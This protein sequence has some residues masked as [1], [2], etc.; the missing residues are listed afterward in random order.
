MQL[1]YKGLT[2]RNTHF[3]VED[4]S[5]VVG[6]WPSIHVIPLVGG[7]RMDV[8]RKQTIIQEIKYWKRSKLLPEHYCDYLLTLYTEGEENTEHGSAEKRKLSSSS[9]T[10]VYSFIFVHLLLFLT[11]V[12]IYFTNFSYVMQIALLVLFFIVSLW[13]A[14]RIVM[15]Y[16]NV[17][18]YYYLLAAIIFI[19]LCLFL[20]QIFF[21]NSKST[22]IAIVLVHFI[23]WLFIGLKWKITYFTIAGAG[24]L[25]LFLLFVFFF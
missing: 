5:V 3:H 19:L 22:L 4:K 8:K 2:S 12:V 24:G 9:I 21:Y 7:D 16:K 25:L 11:I 15:T 18:Y 13:I 17:G 23:C 10:F 1:S 20:N 6:V 14:K